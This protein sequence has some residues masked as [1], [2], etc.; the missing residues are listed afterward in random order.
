MKVGKNE[1]ANLNFGSHKPIINYS[2]AYLCIDLLILWGAE[3]IY[4]F[5]KSAGLGFSRARRF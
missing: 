5:K 4:V 2:G 1:L 3:I